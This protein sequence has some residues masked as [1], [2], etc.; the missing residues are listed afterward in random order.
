MRRCCSLSLVFVGESGDGSE[1]HDRLRD[2]QSMGVGK[3]DRRDPRCGAMAYVATDSC[4]AGVG[5]MG[6][7]LV[8]LLASTVLRR[9][10]IGWRGSQPRDGEPG[11]PLNPIPSQASGG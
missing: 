3:D 2:R 1:Q 6:P 7:R 5:V 11:L 10:G 4:S 8:E 9:N